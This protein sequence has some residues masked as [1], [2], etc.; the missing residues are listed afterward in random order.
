MPTLIRSGFSG[1]TLVVALVLLGLA[2]AVQAEAAS[3][4]DDEAIIDVARSYFGHMDTQR[5]DAARRLLSDTVEF[6][7]PTWGGAPLIGPD[8]VIDAYSNTAGFSN[9]LIEERLA[10]ASRGTAVFHYVVSLSF[11]P[12]ED[13]P[14][15]APVPVIADLVRM[16]T[17]ENGKIVRHMDLAHYPKLELALKQA[18]DRIAGQK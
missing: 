4:L 11:T 9:V 16:A 12:P 8:A 2:P 17:V 6:E 1:A 13:S 5:F 7:D 15:K 18:E 3:P 14:V 10:F